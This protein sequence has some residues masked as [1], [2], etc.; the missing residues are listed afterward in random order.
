V[1]DIS[2]G[3]A[4]AAY[5]GEQFA[6]RYPK[7]YLFALQQASTI[8]AKPPVAGTALAIFWNWMEEH[9]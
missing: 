9:S 2:G 7:L 3:L 8:G 5:W 6:T 1:A 4:A